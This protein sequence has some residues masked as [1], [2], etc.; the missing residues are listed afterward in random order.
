MFELNISK[1]IK[2]Q[3]YFTTNK[4]EYVILSNHD[5]TENRKIFFSCH[6]D[7]TENYDDLNT[8]II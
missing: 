3:P 6:S 7:E 1:K 8:I 5:A 4:Y 2:I